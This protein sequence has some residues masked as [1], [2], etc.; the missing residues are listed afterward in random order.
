[1]TLLPKYRPLGRWRGIGNPLEHMGIQQTNWGLKQLKFGLELRTMISLGIWS[2]VQKPHL[3]FFRVR[4]LTFEPFQY[5]VGVLCRC[6]V[7][8][9]ICHWENYWGL[10]SYFLGPW[11]ISKW[12]V[13]RNLWYH[14]VGKVFFPPWLCS[15]VCVLPRALVRVIQ[16]GN[17]KTVYFSAAPTTTKRQHFSYTKNLIPQA[18]PHQIHMFFLAIIPSMVQT[19]QPLNLMSSPTTQQGPPNFKLVYKPIWL[20]IY[21]ILE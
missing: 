17:L 4:L 14:R 2:H 3:I 13:D 19:L 20:Y 7:S 15:C 8:I 1:M 12:R 10:C 5:F 16:M 6:A 9:P 18:K 21:N 11:N